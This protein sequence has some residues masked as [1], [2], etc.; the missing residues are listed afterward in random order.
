MSALVNTNACGRVSN[1]SVRAV[2]YAL[3]VM[4]T[5]SAGRSYGLALS[6]T[7]HGAIFC[8]AR[9][10]HFPCNRAAFCP[11]ISEKSSALK[12]PYFSCIRE[13]WPRSCLLSLD[14]RSIICPR[15]S[16]MVCGSR[17]SNSCAFIDASSRATIS[18]FMLRLFASARALRSS[19][20]PSG[21]R[22]MNLSEYVRFSMSL[23]LSDGHIFQLDTMLSNGHYKAS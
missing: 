15:I 3:G 18:A 23:M 8:A 17:M 14:S 10:S 21:S 7:P 16:S 1:T 2:R 6:R 13:I 20:I 12:G 11:S 19:R 9:V 5:Q 4:A 22:S